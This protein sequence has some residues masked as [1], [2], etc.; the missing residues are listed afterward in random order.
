MTHQVRSLIGRLLTL[1]FA[2]VHSKGLKIGLYTALG[3]QTCAMAG[4]FPN[5]DVGLGCDYDAFPAC[6]RAKQD[7]E[8]F[9][10]WV[11]SPPTPNPP[12]LPPPPILPHHLLL[13]EWLHGNHARGL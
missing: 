6:T 8:D 9:V 4:L 7:I 5:G 1:T 13:L 3:E 2:D 10:S 11:G 12:T